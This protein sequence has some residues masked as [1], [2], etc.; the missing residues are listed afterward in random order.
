MRFSTNWLSEYVDFK[1]VVSVPQLSDRLTRC[2]FEVES[3]EKDIPLDKV[4]LGTVL[5][6][7]SHPNADKLLLCQVSVGS[8]VTHQIVCGG[9]NFK[10]NDRVVVALP[11]ARLPCGV[12]IKKS[13]IRGVESCGM[14][15][16]ESELSISDEADGIMVLEKNAPCDGTLFDDYYKKDSILDVSIG[17]NRPDAL[18]HFGLAREIASILKLPIKDPEAVD[19]LDLKKS[20]IHVDIRSDLCPRYIGLLVKGV[21]IKESPHHIKNYLKAVNINAVNNVV[22]ITNFIMLELGQP[23]HAFDVNNIN[24]KITVKEACSNDKFQALDGSQIKLTSGDLTIR[25]ESGVIALAGIIGGES[26]KVTEDTKDIFI[27]AACFLKE[28]V[29]KTSRRIGIET[30]SSY[31][32]S[33]GV[34]AFMPELAIKRAAKLICD[35]TGGV[36][37]CYIDNYPSPK[38][39]TKAISI[40]KEQVSSRLGY[41]VDIDSMKKYFGLIGCKVSGSGGK[42]GGS[43]EVIPS[44]HRSDLLLK[45][46]LIEEYV[47]LDGFS[48]I[49]SKKP[50]ISNSLRKHAPFYTLSKKLKTLVKSQ[51]YNQIINYAF[52]DGC[53]ES[54]LLGKVDSILECG[55]STTNEAVKLINPLSQDLDVMRR[56]LVS[57]L[58]KTMSHNARH[59]ESFGRLFE[60]G[61]VFYKSEKVCE[62]EFK[63]REEFRLGIVAWGSKRSLLTDNKTPLIL[64]VKSDLENI[65]KSFFVSFEWQDGV[66]DYINGVRGGR[67]VLGNKSAGYLG[68]V[69]PK[70]KSEFELLECV[71]GE[72]SLDK[73]FEKLPKKHTIKPFS[74]YPRIER[75]ISLIVSQDIKISDL[76]KTIKKQAGPVLIKV[77]PFDIYPGGMEAGKV[78]LGIRCV[79]QSSKKSLKDADINSIQD[80]VVNAVGLKFSAKLR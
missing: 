36:A 49:P 34:E 28:P 35:I 18:N 67:L 65:L 38:E 75:D 74:K 76:I 43:L 52:T 58:I 40:S 6:V 5:D 27:E 20:S 12:K 71:V 21:E 31:R 23:L 77:Y 19:I 14:I 4:V 26:S 15:C 62:E 48:K 13:K 70:I 63:Y 37:T 55:L 24:K 2:G 80:R 41:L 42:V 69:H 8:D 72:I 22:D 9:K 60:V 57:G 39:Q 66:P 68:E 53:L 56:G 44:I 78:A 7:I 17:S 47:R 51:G 59:G 50:F 29:R 25:D 32:F 10:K 79:Y 1:S 46:D 73:L 11:G 30:D 61:P 16:S 54:K 64:D 3:L 45:E 33:K